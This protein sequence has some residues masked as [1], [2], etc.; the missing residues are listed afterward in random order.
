[1]SA[2]DEDKAHLRGQ[3]VCVLRRNSRYWLGVSSW[4]ESIE[5]AKMFPADQMETRARVDIGMPCEM[6]YVAPRVIEG[7]PVHI[8]GE[9]KK[10]RK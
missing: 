1:M 2:P 7:A 6:I 4:S 9:A 3:K 8:V 5:L 10:S